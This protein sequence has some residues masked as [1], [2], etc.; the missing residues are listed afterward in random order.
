LL[1]ETVKNGLYKFPNVGFISSDVLPYLQN[2]GNVAEVKTNRTFETLNLEP[3]N[4]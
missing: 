4:L 2:I 1:Q 3:L